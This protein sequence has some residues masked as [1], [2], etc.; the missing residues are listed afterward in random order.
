MSLEL[1]AVWRDR[2]Q[3]TGATTN[4][5]DTV[6]A[7]AYEVMMVAFTG[8]LVAARLT[9]KVD[10]LHPTRFAEPL[11]VP[12]DGCLPDARGVL[13]GRFQQLARTQWTVGLDE[14]AANDSS[15]VRVALHHHRTV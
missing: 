15:L 12:V 5:E 9:R 6:T 14:N 4:F 3:I 7:P 2:I 8:H 11:Q 1:E 13:S 10:D